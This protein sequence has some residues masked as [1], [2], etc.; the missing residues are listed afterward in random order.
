M[1]QIISNYLSKRF[2]SKFKSVG[3][4]FIVEH[5]RRSSF[6][7]EKI[8]IGNNVFIGSRAWFSGEIEIQNNV[9]FGPGVSIIGGDHLFG[10]KGESVRFLKPNSNENMRKIIVEDE[11]WVAANCT[12]NK[13]VKLGIGCVIGA[14]SLVSKSIPP[15]TVAV[16]NP[17]KP[18][19]KIFADK[20]LVEH[21][22]ILGYSEI[23]ISNVIASRKESLDK[24]GLS[25]I[26]VYINPFKNKD[27]FK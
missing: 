1:R 15:Y 4:N 27:S 19:K 2:L 5:Y 13:G 26:E 17:C 23:F 7:F 24:F 6:T 20:E 10:I 11:V 8:S 18:I 16:G 21:L 3:L 12:I 25:D 9:M 22:S 14:S